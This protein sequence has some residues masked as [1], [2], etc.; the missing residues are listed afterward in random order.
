MMIDAEMYGM[1]PSAKTVKLRQ[2]AARE[3]VEQAQDAALLALEKL[4][5]LVRVDTR[6]RN[7]RPDAI[8]HNA[9]S[10]NRQADAGRRT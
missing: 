9:S 8:D 2:R 6:H 3:H 7:M 4:R 10:K 1:M 5:Q